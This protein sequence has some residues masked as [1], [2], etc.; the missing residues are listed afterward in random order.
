MDTTITKPLA[1]A[2]AAARR[3]TL[4]YDRVFISDISNT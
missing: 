1:K 2:M 3:A 4:R